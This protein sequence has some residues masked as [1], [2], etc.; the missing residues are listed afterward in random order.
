M[1]HLLDQNG[2]VLNV[3]IDEACVLYGVELGKVDV[4]S[5]LLKEFLRCLLFVLE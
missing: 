5:D 1:H 3:P 2:T 4:I